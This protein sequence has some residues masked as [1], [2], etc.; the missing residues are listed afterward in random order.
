MCL[1]GFTT[2]LFQS[3]PDYGSW[4]GSSRTEAVVIYADSVKKKKMNKHKYRKTQANSLPG[5]RGP[6]GE[7]VLQTH[8]SKACSSR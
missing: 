8:S 4:F 6:I 2:L 5:A 3:V 1:C 7:N